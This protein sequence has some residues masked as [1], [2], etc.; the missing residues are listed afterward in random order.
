MCQF[1]SSQMS[2][3]ARCQ[4]AQRRHRSMPPPHTPCSL[5]HHVLSVLKPGIS[6]VPLAAQLG[7]VEALMEQSRQE[8]G[9][10]AMDSLQGLGAGPLLAPSS[11]NS[12]ASSTLVRCRP[13]LDSAACLCVPGSHSILTT[14][15]PK[16]CY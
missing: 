3:K 6:R 13:M 10:R 11:A 12:S 16:H 5:L 2:C 9:Q 15:F 14:A 8:A 4:G 7:Q 1:I